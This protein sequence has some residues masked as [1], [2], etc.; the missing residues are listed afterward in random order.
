MNTRFLS[1]A[2]GL[3]LLAVWMNT[4]LSLRA[5]G[6]GE[7]C[8][9]FLGDYPGKTT[10]GWNQNAQGFAHDR[11]HWFITQ[12]LK[13]WKIPVGHDLNANAVGFPTVSM[14]DTPL[15]EEGYNHFGDPECYEFRGQTFVLVPV[16]GDGFAP[17]PAVALFHAD[18][19]AYID[20]AYLDQQ[21]NAPWCAVDPQG[22]FYSSNFDVNSTHRVRK[23]NV[24]WERVIASGELR[25]TFISTIPLLDEGGV[26]M[27]LPHVQGGVIT[28][29]GTLMYLV[30]GD[31]ETV[32]VLETDGIHA[33][34]METES[35]R[36][37]TRST[38]GFG[39]FNFEFHPEFP[40]KEEPE[41][42]TFWDLDDGRAPGMSGQL[43]VL[44]LDN[45]VPDDDCILVKHYAAT[46]HV[47]RIFNGTEIGSLREPFNTVNEANDLVW[48]GGQISIRAGS[49]PETL[50]F[51]K[52]IAV[53]ANGGPVT[54]GQ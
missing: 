5:Q 31:G 45:D 15:S 12:W 22:H 51:S 25:L 49:Y 11:D 17:H 40:I 29:G 16:E 7:S 28:P 42:L 2:R 8:Y 4:G 53:V 54:I 6:F 18:T 50:T 21:A 19:L 20:H 35:G 14:G 44:L 33:F 37:V 47:D 23:Y 36:R 1:A 9:Y 46:L 10:P 34:E 27:S 30:A 26:E 41:G 13:I 3:S 52:R 38:R 39:L 24:E 48:D 32:P 43:H